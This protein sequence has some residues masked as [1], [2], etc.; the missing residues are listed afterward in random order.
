MEN[1]KKSEK[2][3]LG[4]TRGAIHT[5]L[6]LFV[7]GMIANLFIEIPANL[8]AELAWRWVFSQ[9]TVIAVHA[10]VGT[11]LLAVSVISLVFGFS[12]RRKAW[13]IASLFGLLFTG[14][15][16]YAGADFVSAGQ[17]DV[18]SL[19]MAFGFLGALVSYSLAVFQPKSA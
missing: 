19:L 15:A 5:L 16:A 17:S 14:L 11:I 1:N 9:S 8:S 7:L 18:S 12:S 10:V 2:L 13:V 3:Y 6:F 4:I